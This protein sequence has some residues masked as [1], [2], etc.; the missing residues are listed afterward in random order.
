MKLEKIKFNLQLAEMISKRSTCL[1]LKVGA[2]L[3]DINGIILSTGYNGVSSGLKH[4]DKT[5]CGSI[6]PCRAIHSEVNAILHSSVDFR[7]PKIIF[8]TD[9][10][11]FSCS[12]IL[13]AFN[14]KEIY[15]LERYRDDIKSMKLLKEAKV[16]IYQFSKK[17]LLEL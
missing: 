1:R 2:V 10:P 12:K 9:S 11:C 3:T 14:I 8:L 7:L 5:N 13:I 16:K 4:C 17:K 6:T 15:F